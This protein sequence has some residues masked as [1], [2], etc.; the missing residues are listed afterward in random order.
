MFW[1][2]AMWLRNYKLW[3]FGSFTQIVVMLE[4]RLEFPTDEFLQICFLVS[5]LV[6]GNSLRYFNNNKRKSLVAEDNM[7]FFRICFWIWICVSN[8]FLNKISLILHLHFFLSSLRFSNLICQAKI[9]M[10]IIL[11]RPSSSKLLKLILLR[12]I[13]RIPISLQENATRIFIKIE[14]IIICV[15]ISKKFFNHFTCNKPIA[16]NFQCC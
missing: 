3:Y 11:S 9:L 4:K 14:Y 2:L 12:S 6:V 15:Q 10:R 16:N 5:Q 7:K 13:L 8:M 1:T